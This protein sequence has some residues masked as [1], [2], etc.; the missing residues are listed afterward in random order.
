MLYSAGASSTQVPR[1]TVCLPSAFVYQSAEPF[2]VTL[3]PLQTLLPAALL[4]IGS[5]VEAARLDL[6]IQPVFRNEPL[7]LDSLRYDSPGSDTYSVTRLSFLLSTFGLRRPDG[8]WLD[9]PRSIAWMDAAAR[10]SV[11]QLPDIPPGTYQALRFHIGPDA[12]ANAADVAKIPAAHPLNPNLNGLHWSWQGGYIFMALE[13]LWRQGS[14]AVQGYSWHF[15][16]D[17]NRTAITLPVDLTLREQGIVLTEFD[18]A[19]LL[20]SPNSPREAGNSTHSAPGDP[21]AAALRA[22]LPAAFRIVSARETADPPPAPATARPAPIDLPVSYQ[23]WP[24]TMNRRFP[25]PALPPDNPLLTARVELGERLFFDPLLSRDGTVSCASCHHPGAAF[26]DPRQFSQGVAGGRPPRH[27]MPLFNLAWKSSFS[28]DGRAPTLRQQVLQPIE[29]HREMDQDLPG[30]VLKL[31]KHPEYPALFAKAFSPAGITAERLALALENFLLTLISHGSKFDRAMNG[32][33]TLTD[34]EKR[35]FELFFMEYEPRSGR[36][37]AD[38]FH[39]HGGADFSDH[40]FHNN[41]LDAD[42]AD[43]GRAAVSGQPGDHGRFSTPSLRNAALTAPYMHDGRFATLEAVLDHYTSGVKP[44]ATLDPNLAKHPGGGIPLTSD[45]KAALV[46]F[47]RSLT[48]DQF[49]DFA[50]AK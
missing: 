41:G 31:T 22:A 26:S 16:N 11:W 20:Q 7:R 47:L 15:A 43:P 19:R 27:G 39:C 45:D 12:A 13:G 24:F 36:L 21:I 2:D 34:L 46:A 29:D 18:L 8:T 5:A 38:C 40:Q 30:L 28:W 50:P 49:A 32:T 1:F 9:F 4:L 17:E 48:D 14:G 25:V 42:P 44:S 6:A 3:R 35:G 33:G 23:P 10:R 37:G